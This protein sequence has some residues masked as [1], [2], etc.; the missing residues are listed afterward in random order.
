MLEKYFETR[1]IN[2]YV[3][4]FFVKLFQNRGADSNFQRGEMNGDIQKTEG[5]LLAL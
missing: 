3:P 1:Y 2:V 4:L 5:I